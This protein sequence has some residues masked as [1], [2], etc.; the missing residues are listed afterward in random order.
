MQKQRRSIPSLYDLSKKS[1]KS[2]ITTS[3]QTPS[4]QFVARARKLL[5]KSTFPLIR[6][7]LLQELLPFEN[8]WQFGCLQSKK[9]S[10]CKLHSECILMYSYTSKV[11]KFLFGADIQSFKRSSN[12][13]IIVIPKASLSHFL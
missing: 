3:I 1:V 7:Q 12:M 8:S 2:W 4:T 5:R 13:N 10:R 11:L 9:R 6:Q